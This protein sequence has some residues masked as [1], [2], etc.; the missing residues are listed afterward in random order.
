ML[1]LQ[2]SKSRIVYLLVFKVK[3]I[4]YGYEQ[5]HKKWASI[6]WIVR[7]FHIAVHTVVTRG[8]GYS[9]DPLDTH[10]PYT[11]ADADAIRELFIQGE[12]DGTTTNCGLGC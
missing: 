2:S 7:H 4:N 11:P 8:G 3:I 10:T 6:N 12:E 5:C 1:T 9:T